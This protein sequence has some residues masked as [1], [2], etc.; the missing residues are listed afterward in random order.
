MLFSSTQT[1]TEP[2]MPTLSLEAPMAA[3]MPNCSWLASACTITL[4]PASTRAPSPM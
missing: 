2:A 1:I 3:A 4:P